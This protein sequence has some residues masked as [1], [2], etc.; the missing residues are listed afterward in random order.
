MKKAKTQSFSLTTQPIQGKGPLWHWKLKM[1]LQKNPTDV[2]LAPTS[3]VYPALSSL[4]PSTQSKSSS[5][6]IALVVHDL[7]AFLYAKHNSRF[8]T[9]V[10]GLTLSRALKN[11]NWIITVSKHHAQRP[12]QPLS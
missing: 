10:E 11:S 7:I 1:H 4:F 12:S 6:K 2:F 5:P 3:F 8:A 9:W